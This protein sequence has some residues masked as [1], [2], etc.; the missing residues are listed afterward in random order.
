MGLL[1]RGV[2][3]RDLAAL[4]PPAAPF[5]D[6]GVDL[7]QRFDD[8]SRS[9]GKL[10]VHRTGLRYVGVLVATYHGKAERQILAGLQRR[11][12]P[13][14]I[15]VEREGADRRIRLLENASIV[16][17]RELSVVTD[18]YFDAWRVLPHGVAEIPTSAETIAEV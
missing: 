10:Q 11:G 7:R 9:V 17:C 14:V 5:G 1:G 3:V 4:D 2:Q 6:E 12:F 15:A 18:G 16:G 13:H 8:C